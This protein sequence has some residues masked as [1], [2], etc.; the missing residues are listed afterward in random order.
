[1]R[2]AALLSDLRGELAAAGLRGSYVARD[3]SSGEELTLDA[4]VELPSASLVKVPLAISVAERIAD[5]RLD[6]AAR[7][8]VAPGGVRT[9]GPMGITRFRHPAQ[10]ALEDLL[11]LSTSL[12]D[13]AA[14]EALFH[15]VPPTDV[16]REMVRLG[17]HGLH[18]RHGL[19]VLTETPAE[20]LRETPHL[21]QALAIEAGSSTGGHPV[22]QLDPAQANTATATAMADLL[23]LVWRPGGLS[24]AAS[25]R[26]REL[27]A[28][29]VMR[30]RLAPEFSSDAMR[31][32]SKTGTMLHLRHE[33]GVVEHADGQR[34]VVVALTES[35]VP[36]AVQPGAEAAMAGVARRLHDELRR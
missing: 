23:E 31:W 35:V 21:A 4:D 14:A 36:A 22:R 29:N 34:I 17:I 18:I 12:S 1:M 30:Q 11:Y 15:L 9:P 19:D 33:A 20:T 32:S 25:E 2:S 10:V 26:V 3:L 28:A 27:L 8:D 16:S 24:E 7:L 6:P 13:N 5:G